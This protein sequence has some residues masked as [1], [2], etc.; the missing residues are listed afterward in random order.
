MFHIPRA[1]FPD[2]HII[3]L[4]SQIPIQHGMKLAYNNWKDS[5]KAIRNKRVSAHSGQPAP[6]P[7]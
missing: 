7:Q 3:S 5:R 2:A 4:M 1:G 6:V